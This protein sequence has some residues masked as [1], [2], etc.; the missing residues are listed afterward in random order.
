VSPETLD[1]FLSWVKLH[2]VDQK[3]KDA[4]AALEYIKGLTNQ[5]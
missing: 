4:V 1:R 2:A 5:V 3:R